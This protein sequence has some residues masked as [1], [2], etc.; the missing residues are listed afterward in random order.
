M[1]PIFGFTDTLEHL[2]YALEAA[3]KSGL[4]YIREMLLNHVNQ[5]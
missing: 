5:N 3:E 2:Q 4:L 1:R